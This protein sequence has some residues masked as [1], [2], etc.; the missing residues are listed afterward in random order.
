[1]YLRKNGKKEPITK[2]INKRKDKR[3]KDIINTKQTRRKDRENYKQKERKNERKRKKERGRS[4][5]S[6]TYISDVHF[7]G[8]PSISSSSVQP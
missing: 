8:V 2:E 6:I 5:L 7:P 3:N 1:M 4:C